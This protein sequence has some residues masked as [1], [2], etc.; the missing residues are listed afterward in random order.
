MNKTVEQDVAYIRA[1]ADLLNEADL[2]AIQ[3]KRDDGYSDDFSDGGE[4]RPRDDVEDDPP[5]VEDDRRAALI[6]PDEDESGGG[7]LSANPTKDTA[8]WAT[9][10]TAVGLAG[11]GGIFGFLAL[12]SKNE[13]DLNTKDSDGK[14]V[15]D[16]TT[17]QREGVPLK[18]AGQRSALI[19]DILYGA[20]IAALITGVCLHL[21]WDA[22]GEPATSVEPK[23]GEEGGEG[24]GWSIGP[25]SL[26]IDF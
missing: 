5:P 1:L 18:D 6:D 14:I 19:A 22:G 7:L 12:S 17:D 2:S 24:W 20:G 8:L 4:D 25:G 23:K 3:L 13:Y 21:F 10:G 11:V 26:R 15:H 16:E 9:Y